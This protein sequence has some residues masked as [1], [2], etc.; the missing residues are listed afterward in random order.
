MK[1]ETNAKVW[2]IKLKMSNLCF[3]ET[4]VE[5]Y[6]LNASLYVYKL[7]RRLIR[8]HLPVGQ[9]ILYSQ[10]LLRF[11]LHEAH[12]LNRHPFL[13]HAFHPPKGRAF[14]SPLLGRY[15]GPYPHP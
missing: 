1:V 15:L 10:L 8:A 11:F 13:G 7:N 5:R 6:R 12:S 9:E 3:H 14:G 2:C 4:P